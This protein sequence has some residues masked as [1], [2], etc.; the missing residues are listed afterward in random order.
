MYVVVVVGDDELFV[1]VDVDVDVDIGLLLLIIDGLHF[2]VILY[3][4]LYTLLL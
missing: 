1:D 4:N 3:L 2:Y